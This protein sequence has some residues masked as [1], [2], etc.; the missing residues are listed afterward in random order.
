MERG[1]RAVALLAHQQL[2]GDGLDG[3]RRARS[4]RS[5]ARAVHHRAGPLVDRR[6]HDGGQRSGDA[7]DVRRQRSRRDGGARSGQPTDRSAA[8]E[9][10]GRHRRI[11]ARRSRRLAAGRHVL[12]SDLRQHHQPRFRGS[13]A[14]DRRARGN[15]L[16][17]AA[18]PAPPPPTAATTWTP[19]ATVPAK[20]GSSAPSSGS[21]A[22]SADGNTFV[23]V[24]RG[25]TPSYSRTTSTEKAGTTWTASTGLTAGMLVAADR[26]NPSKFY[27]RRPERDRREHRRGRD[28]RAGVARRR[29]G[30]RDRCSE[31]K[32]TSGSRR[33]PGLLHSQDSGAT[34][35]PVAAVNGATAVGFGMPAG[36]AEPTRPSTWRAP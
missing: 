12:Q 24:P 31:S 2:A 6:R 23:W 1:R 20:T 17:A 33:A 34:F 35:Q 19:F 9:R 27:A 11:Q 30:G 14:A 16:V 21:I 3:R 26:V 28:V 18:R 13:R 25:G 7:L 15:Q 10:R 22:V 8:A 32:G 29:P 4:L 36:R 5:V